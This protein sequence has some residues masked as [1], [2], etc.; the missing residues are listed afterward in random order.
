MRFARFLYWGLMTASVLSRALAQEVTITQLRSFLLDQH[1]AKSPDNETAHHL[2]SVSLTER[3]TD[4][5]LN[6]MINETM[7]GPESVEQ[8]RLLAD[9][10]IFAALPS[11]EGPIFPAPE[12]G[13]Q[14][15]MLR[16]GA[17]YAHTSLQ[18]LPDFLAIRD[19]RRF[20]NTPQASGSRHTKPKIQLH[21]TGEF[22]EQITYSDGAEIAGDSAGK[23]TT[24]AETMMH[25]GLLSVGEFG[26]ILS[27]V[28]S[29]SAQGGLRWAR[30]EMDSVVGRLAV[31]R[32]TVPK[33]RSHYLVD[34]CCYTRPDDETQEFPFRDHPAYH[35]EVALSSDSGIVRR[36]TIQA[37]LESSAPIL[38]SGLAVQYGEVEIGARA[39]ICPVRSIAMTTLHN[40]KMERIDGIG[41]ERH[42]NEIEYLDYHKFG[43]TS[44]MVPND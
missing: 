14:E 33:S 3:L 26:P 31:F 4:Q 39:Y 16:A 43:S 44:R 13:A 2:N 23:Q 40:H 19:T 11:R 6:R 21:W 7:P 28:F 25:P 12:S 20:D 32:Y 42:L 34:F 35:G 27:V 17:E 38:T 24:S 5:A 15:A 1:K 18:R 22:K 41:I 36:I 29:D 9:A 8:L 10:S 37:D 30:W